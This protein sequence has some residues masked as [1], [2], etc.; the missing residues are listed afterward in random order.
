M[1]DPEALKIGDVRAQIDAID[2]DL[3]RLITQRC[4][5][6]A[7]VGAAKK[8]AG[9]VAFGWRPGREIEILRQV[10]GTMPEL[11]PKLAYSVWRALISANL[12]AQG[13]LTVLALRES[14]SAAQAAFSAGSPVEVAGDAH[15]LLSRV[16]SDDHTIGVVPF[17]AGATHWWARMTDVRF[18]AVH[19]C[20]AAPLVNSLETPK[21]LMLA[22]RKPEQAGG[23]ISLIATRDDT[24]K[25]NIIDQIDGMSLVAIAG[26]VSEVPD[27]SRLIGTYA[28]I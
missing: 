14:V 5:L 23:D 25:G 11:D 1:N 22:K 13:D 18:S 9:D 20:A 21:A 27:G 6:S 4:A 19:V 7:S 28:L 16:S 2:R 26:F 24:T 8:A 12:T 17:V 3:A 10:L 15:E